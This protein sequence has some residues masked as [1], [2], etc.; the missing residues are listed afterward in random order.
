MTVVGWVTASELGIWVGIFIGF[1]GLAVNLYFK[2]KQ[3]R[4]SEAA[5]AAFMAKLHKGDEH[6][7]PLA[8]HH[9]ELDE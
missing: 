2:R 8:P 4:R 7:V 1:A 3:D 9:L 6:V 5:H